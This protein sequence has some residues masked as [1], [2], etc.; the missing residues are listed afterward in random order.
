MTENEIQHLLYHESG[1]KGLSGV[2]GDVRQLVASGD[3]GAKLA[4]DYFAYRTAESIAGLCVSIKGIDAL[5]FT[6]GVGENSAIVRSSICD[7]LSWM[8]VKLDAALNKKNATHISSMHSP[9][10]VYVVPTNEELIIARQTLE[11]LNAL[12]Q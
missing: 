8:G 2:S 7:H 3:P 1:L 10:Q 9:I 12:Q 6:A 4:L 11:K 5:V